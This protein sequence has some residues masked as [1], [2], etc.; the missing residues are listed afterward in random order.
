MAARVLDLRLRDADADRGD[1]EAAQPSIEYDLWL[2]W[3][4]ARI[5]ANEAAMNA[6]GMAVTRP[7]ND[8]CP[9]GDLPPAS[10]GPA[11]VGFSLAPPAL[12][13]GTM[14]TFYTPMYAASASALDGR[15]VPLDRH[16]V[17]RPRLDDPS[18]WPRR[19]PDGAVHRL[20]DAPLR[21]REPLRPPTRRRST[22]VARRTQRSRRYCPPPFRSRTTG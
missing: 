8:W 14:G 2:K 11:R 3:N 22:S 20:V 17:R 10:T 19:L 1:D 6:I 16:G 15:D 21:R 7:I 4:Q 5:D 12:R 13:A 18:P 9:N